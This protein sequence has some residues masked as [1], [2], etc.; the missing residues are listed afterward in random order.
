MQ[1]PRL[2]AKGGTIQTVLCLKILSSKQIK[3][4]FRASPNNLLDTS[5]KYTPERPEIV[6]T[7]RELKG[8]IEA[9]LSDN[10]VSLTKDALKLVS[11]NSIEYIPRQCT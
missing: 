8:G 11:K 10:D 7:T 5:E 1:S 2:Q 6:I 9:D 4:R 3:Y